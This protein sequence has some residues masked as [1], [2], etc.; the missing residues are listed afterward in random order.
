MSFRDIIR[1]VLKTIIITL[2]FAPLLIGAFYLIHSNVNIAYY[3]SDVLDIPRDLSLTV[4]SA[5]FA[6]NI[7]R[8]N[9]KIKVTI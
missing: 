7:I 6:N 5:G 4:M 3:I 2:V 1:I 8:V 9:S